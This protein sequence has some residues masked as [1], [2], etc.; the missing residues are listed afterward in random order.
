MKFCAHHWEALR[1][2]VDR[3]GLGA[4]VA[5]SGEAVGAKID[6]A[7]ADGP[8]FDSFDP[9]LAAHNAIAVNALRTAGLV[10]MEPE[11][12]G[13]PRCPLCFL[14]AHGPT[15]DAFDGWITAAVDEQ[16]EYLRGLGG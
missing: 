16:V 5:E 10:L 11:A 1:G 3:R 2:E 8:S 6:R 13:S 15:P 7:A 14:N 4:L 9:L 12:D